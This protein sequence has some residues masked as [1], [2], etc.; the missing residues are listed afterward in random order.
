MKRTHGKTR[1]EAW[2]TWVNMIQRCSNSNHPDYEYYGGRGIEV[3][4]DWLDFLNFLRDMGERPTS[5]HTLD[6]I[7]NNLGYSKSN[8]RWATRKEQSMNTRRNVMVTIEGKTK[9]L[10]QWCSELGLRY[11]MVHHRVRHLGVDPIKAMAIRGNARW[12]TF[13]T[14]KK[15]G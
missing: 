11:D 1:T 4:A 6:R 13:T 8:C 9:C 5:K 7:N 10:K 14:K 2:N 15:G 12:G 3:C